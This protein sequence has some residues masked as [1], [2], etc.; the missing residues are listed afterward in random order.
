MTSPSPGF[1]LLTDLPVYLGIQLGMG[2]FVLRRVWWVYSR[3]SLDADGC[4]EE[5]MARRRSRVGGLI[6]F[7]I[8]FIMISIGGVSLAGANRDYRMIVPT[9][10][11]GPLI[12]FIVAG[13]MAAADKRR[14]YVN[15]RRRKPQSSLTGQSSVADGS[16]P[17]APE[18]PPMGSVRRKSRGSF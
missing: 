1:S 11:L 14:G 6:I 8:L 13:M 17:E 7:Y 5:T 9:L 2:L 10:F 18:A 4:N 3:K 12:F 15:P 16:A